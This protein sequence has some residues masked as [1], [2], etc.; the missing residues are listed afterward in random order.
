MQSTIEPCRHQLTH[1]PNVVDMD[2]TSYLTFQCVIC[3]WTIGLSLDPEGNVYRQVI[4]PP[5]W[6]CA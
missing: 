3:G 4:V 5:D 6:K 2:G 1:P